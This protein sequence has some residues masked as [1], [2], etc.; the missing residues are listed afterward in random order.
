MKSYNKI[1]SEIRKSEKVSGKSNKISGH[2]GMIEYIQTNEIKNKEEIYGITMTEIPKVGINPRSRHDTPIGIY[3]YPLDFY[4]ETIENE[5]DE[6]PFQHNAKY[7]NLIK[8]NKGYVV[9]DINDIDS[10][11]FQKEVQKIKSISLLSSDVSQEVI[12][13]IV[14]ESSTQSPVISPGGKLW[15]VLSSLTIYLSSRSNVFFKT[16]V[17]SPVIWNWL[18]RRMGYNVVIDSGSGIIH[19]NEETQGL[20]LSIKDF[21]IVK[22]IENNKKFGEYNNSD[23]FKLLY[24]KNISDDEIKQIIS[25]KIPYTLNNRY[26]LSAS[27]NRKATYDKIV[28]LINTKSKG[29]K[30]HFVSRYLHSIYD[31]N[32]L[33]ESDYLSIIEKYINFP[34]NEDLMDKLTELSNKEIILFYYLMRDSDG[35]SHLEYFDWR[36]LNLSK[37]FLETCLFYN[38]TFT[39]SYGSSFK[40]TLEEYLENLKY[41]TI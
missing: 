37:K 13:E 6:L 1:L 32:G 31:I 29:V 16:K 24:M 35:I 3:F 21:V 26:S 18:L 9:L 38:E 39:K 7:I 28:K 34:K 33:T 27:S 19:P 4:K 2:L 8:S 25:T 17:K 23:L 11:G 40:R 5:Y 10:D 41:E 22:T 30:I 15:Y 12:D 36:N 20:F 14:K